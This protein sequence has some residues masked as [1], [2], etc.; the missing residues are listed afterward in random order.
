MS[1]VSKEGC[2]SLVNIRVL[3]LSVQGLI[4]LEVSHEY[5]LTTARNIAID[6]FSQGSESLQFTPMTAMVRCTTYKYLISTPM[7]LRT[8][9][10]FASLISS[11]EHLVR[12]TVFGQFARLVSG[13]R[14]LR[15]PNET[16]L[17][18]QTNSTQEKSVASPTEESRTLDPENT[19]SNGEQKKIDL[20]DWYGTDDPEVGVSRCGP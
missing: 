15:F 1:I 19:S 10:A 16:D 4:L 5:S 12:D 13:R 11:M 7:E 20:V 9:S 2:I 17:S 3:A 18:A 6:S 8:C 14:L